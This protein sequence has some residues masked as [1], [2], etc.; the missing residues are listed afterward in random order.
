MLGGEEIFHGKP[1]G[2]S[3]LGIQ[4]TQ[5]SNIHI[6]VDVHELQTS[7]PAFEIFSSSTDRSDGDDHEGRQHNTN[8]SVFHDLPP[9]KKFTQKKE[10]H[11][12][13]PEIP[14]LMNSVIPS[15][16]PASKH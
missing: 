1:T 12:A 13:V 11:H 14:F 9:N 3:R 15:L 2:D 10:R 8:N 4:N 16:V 6:R 5:I 7:T